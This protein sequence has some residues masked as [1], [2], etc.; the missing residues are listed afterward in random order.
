MNLIKAVDL[1]AGIGGMRKG[2]ENTG[3]FHTVYANDF[4][5]YC[6]KTYD[7]NFGDTKLTVKD[8]RNI[9]VREDEIPEFDFLLA[10][11]PCQPFSLG[12]NRQG[13]SDSKGRGRLFEEI[14]RLLK[15]AK[16]NCGKLPVG[17]LL[18]N[19]KNLKTHNDTKT[20]N[21][22][23]NGLEA[24]GYIVASRI[25]NSLDFGVA[26]HRERLYIIGFSSSLAFENFHWPDPTHK[27]HQY[28]KV[29]DILE[30]RIKPKFYYNDKPLYDKIKQTV[31]N[32]DFV[33]NYR[34]TYVRSFK[35]GYAPTLVASMGLG[36]HNVPIIKDSKGV[37]KLT[38]R[39][40]ARLQ[41]YYDLFIPHDIADYRIYKQLG[42][43]VAVPVIQAIA[44]RIAQAIKSTKTTTQ[45]K[46]SKK[47][48]IRV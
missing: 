3:Y 8:I 41:G 14:I 7:E 22:I 42:N 30:S 46:L 16:D 32:P 20:Y 26:Q 25:Y 4:D 17:F 27:S 44:E 11:F 12:G 37:R 15:E 5:E 9:N 18:E 10:G 24:L 43:T 21:T 35:Q 31:V 47:K 28:A 38:P 23:C 2:C 48:L 36:G 33:Y 29:K 45:Q 1:F 19:V 6:K 13:F 34:R 40:C 39:E